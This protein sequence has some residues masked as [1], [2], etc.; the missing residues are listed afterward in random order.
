MALWPVIAGSGSFVGSH[1]LLSHPWRRPLVSRLGESGFL[2]LYSAVAAATLAAAAIGYRVAGPETPLWA[3]GDGLWLAAT[4]LMLL[5]SVLLVGSLV[6]NP[7]AP[8]LGSDADTPAGP[9]AGVFAI[10]RHPMMWSF[11]LWAASHALVYPVPANLVLSGAIAALSLGGAAAQDRKKQA[12]LPVRWRLWQQETSYWPFAA[13][14]SGRTRFR[15]LG[16]HALGG[17][18]AVWL[19]A[20]WLHGPL[21]G[22]PAGIWRWA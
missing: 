2:G 4:V 8:R 7:A 20:T 18:V 11:A 6:R 19:V 21:A 1:L 10:T 5:A 9:P 17:G 16:L 15:P 22:W 12:L 13:I 14:L 3:I